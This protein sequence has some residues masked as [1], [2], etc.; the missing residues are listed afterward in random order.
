MTGAL[1]RCHS[2]PIRRGV[3][4]LQH[5]FNQSSPMLR[6]LADLSPTCPHCLEGYE[7]LERMPA[8]PKCMVL[9]T[10]ILAGDSA[11]VAAEEG[12][13]DQRFA[14]YWEEEGWPL[15]TRLR[16]VLG[17]G[18]Y[19]PEVNVWDVSLL[20]PPAIVWTHEDPPLPSDRTHNL[21]EYE[22]ERPRITA[23]LWV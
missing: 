1:H 15:S 22:P 10:A 3:H 19:D 4:R 14:Q 7:M 20:H 8:G 16:P 6:V 5:G 17:Q 12:R 2:V 11:D 13:S 23:A 9:W 21:R 18:T